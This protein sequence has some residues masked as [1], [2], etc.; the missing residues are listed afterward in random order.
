VGDRNDRA[1]SKLQLYQLLDL[2]LSNDVDVCRSFVKHNDFVFAEN[3]S[4]DA[5]ELPFTSTQIRSSF[6]DLEVD[7]L[8]FFLV[9]LALTHVSVQVVCRLQTR[10]FS[11]VLDILVLVFPSLFWLTAEKITETGL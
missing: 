11:L 5:N 7:A 9:V 4:T 10:N 6:T 1:L 8:L 2:L 3:G